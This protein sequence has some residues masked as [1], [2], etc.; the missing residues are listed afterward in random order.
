[1][2]VCVV[3]EGK[4]KEGTQ[5][6]LFAS[7]ISCLGFSVP[8]GAHMLVT[9]PRGCLLSRILLSVVSWVPRHL[10]NIKHRLRYQSV[11]IVVYS[12][13]VSLVQQPPQLVCSCSNRDLHARSWSWWH[14]IWHARSLFFG[15]EEQEKGRF[16]PRILMKEDLLDAFS[17]FSKVTY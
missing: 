10:I 1:M 4:G 7:L 3:V 15:S 8:V 9:G 5:T 2:Y 6:K 12:L 14:K 11:I 17:K 13:Y 16:Q